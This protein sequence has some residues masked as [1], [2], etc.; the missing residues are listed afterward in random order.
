M[1]NNWKTESVPQ[2][3]SVVNSKITTNTCG[4]YNLGDI[5]LYISSRASIDYCMITDTQLHN[6][7]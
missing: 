3:M 7:T 2:E 5:H 1:L 4:S 6:Y